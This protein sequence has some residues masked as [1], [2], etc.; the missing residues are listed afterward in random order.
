M[1]FAPGFIVAYLDSKNTYIQY[2]SHLIIQGGGKAERFYTFS[3]KN[4]DEV[5]HLSFP[6]QGPPPY[7]RLRW[8]IMANTQR[9]NSVKH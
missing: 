6:H 5:C 2:Q 1:S 7:S 3:L 4:N 9:W 8:T